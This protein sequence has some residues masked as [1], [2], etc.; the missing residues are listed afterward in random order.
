M[1]H[2]IVKSQHYR[3]V[4]ADRQGLALVSPTCS[5]WGFEGFTHHI[6]VTAGSRSSYHLSSTMQ[7][8]TSGEL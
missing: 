2:P 3:Y 1:K 6:I 7:V 5:L 8:Q 4:S